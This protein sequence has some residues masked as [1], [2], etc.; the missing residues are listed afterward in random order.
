MGKG[1]KNFEYLKLNASRPVCFLD[2]CGVVGDIYGVREGGRKFELNGLIQKSPGYRGD[3][4]WIPA[5]ATLRA[6]LVKH[7]VQVVIVSS[8]VPP[9]L[10]A[11][12]EQILLLKEYLQLPN[13]HGSIYTGGGSQRGEAVERC[14]R[15]LKLRDWVVIDDSR[16][17]M[18]EN[19]HF[20]SNN[21][22]IQP[23]GRYGF[24]LRE[25]E[26]LDYILSKESHDFLNYEFDM[27]SPSTYVDG[28]PVHVLNVEMSDAGAE[29]FFANGS[30]VSLSHLKVTEL[31]YSY[32]L[33]QR[34]TGESVPFN[35]L[36][37]KTEV[38]AL[39]KVSLRT[40]ERMMNAERF[41]GPTVRLRNSGRWCD[42]VVLDWLST[43]AIA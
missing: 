8:W 3:D 19:R 37:T 33:I 27:R 14:V 9:Y 26:Q 21:R 36:L 5:I 43:E 41:P 35:T 25:M 31:P 13:I 28:D 16:E 10:A 40:L 2:L 29:L 39:L 23:H 18:Y 32:S 11:D 6:V 42:S 30:K 22:F 17:Q 12:A 38:A 4:L 15:T 24:G 34:E 7:E 1:M 20:F